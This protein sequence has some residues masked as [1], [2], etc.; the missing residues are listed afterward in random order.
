[1]ESAAAA[2]RHAH[3]ARVPGEVDR[4][5]AGGVAPADHQHVLV[6]E[7]LGVGRHGRVVET[8]AAIALAAS[9]TASSRHRAPVAISTVRPS[10]YWPSSRS[11]RTRPSG[12]SVSSTARWKLDRTASKRRACSVA[13][14]VSSAPEMPVGKPR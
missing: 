13:A 11:T 12:P 8:R 9:G 14:R 10:T 7:A 4:R 6:A 1:M 5:L 2:H 3:A